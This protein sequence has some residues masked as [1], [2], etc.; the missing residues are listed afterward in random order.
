MKSPHLAK[1]HRYKLGYTV[2]EVHADRAE[3]WREILCIQEK[4]TFG[5][6]KTVKWHRLSLQLPPSRIT[7]ARAA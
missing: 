2:T 5:N 3:M 6:D 7:I 4:R 1:R